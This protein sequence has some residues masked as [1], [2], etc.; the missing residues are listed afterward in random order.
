[1]PLHKR[2]WLLLWGLSRIIFLL[3]WVLAKVV[4]Y[5]A[6]ELGILTSA[7]KARYES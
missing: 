2:G 3:F 6:V 4:Y 5:P 7:L 1:M